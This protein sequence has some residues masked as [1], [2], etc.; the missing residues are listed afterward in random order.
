MSSTGGVEVGACASGGK[1]WSSGGAFFVTGGHFEGGKLL[2][3]SPEGA[4]TVLVDGLPSLGDHHT[5]APVVMD[6][7]VYFG[8]GTAT[9]SAVVGLDCRADHRSVSTKS[10]QG[11]IGSTAKRA[12]AGHPRDGLD[13][14]CLA[15]AVLP[16]NRSQA[17]AE[18]HL[19]TAI[20]TPVGERQASDLHASVS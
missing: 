10:N 14:I 19:G 15:V 18:R 16:D 7:W 12:D 9:N 2:R 6:G 8:Q 4:V 5:N 20:R 3:I 1:F 17:V 11:I 13:E